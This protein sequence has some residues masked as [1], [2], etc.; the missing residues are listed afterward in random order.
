MLGIA[1][2]VISENAITPSSNEIFRIWFGIEWTENENDGPT[3]KFNG[4]V[5]IEEGWED[6]RFIKF[7]D[8][9]S[10]VKFKRLLKQST[11]K[12]LSHRNPKYSEYSNLEMAREMFMKYSTAIEW[13]KM[14]ELMQTIRINDLYN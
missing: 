11:F 14:F 5:G 2:S 1:I 13:S 10:A 8:R 12:S 9:Q 4:N 3:F 7:A 6:E